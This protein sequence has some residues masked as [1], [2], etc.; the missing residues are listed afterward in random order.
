MHINLNPRIYLNAH[1]KS[2]PCASSSFFL[3]ASVF[4][5]SAS[6]P[7][8]FFFGSSE[9]TDMA[10]VGSGIVKSECEGK[11]ARRLRVASLTQGHFARLPFMDLAQFI[12]LTFTYLTIVH[13]LPL[14]RTLSG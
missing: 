5:P 6:L 1:T 11:N 3:D 14:P 13:E 9:G 12:T 8:F 10:M 2:S 4:S 7:S